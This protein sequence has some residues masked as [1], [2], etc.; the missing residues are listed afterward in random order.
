MRRISIAAFILFTIFNFAGC[1]ESEKIRT[2]RTKFELAKMK[3]DLD[4]M[5]I[6][7]K[8]LD[9]FGDKNAKN[10]LLVVL[11]AIKERELMLTAQSDHDHE[12]ALAAADKLITFSPG[13]KDAIKAIRESGQI[14]W[15]L[16][17]AQRAL[18]EFSDPINCKEVKAAEMP[19]GL[20]E[21]G[22][23]KWR[24]DTIQNCLIVL[25]KTIDDPKGSFGSSTK[26]ALKEEFP[27]MK[28]VQLNDELV[29]TVSKAAAEHAKSIMEAS[30]EESKF[31]AIA[32]A[33]NLVSK[34]K[35]LDPQFKGSVQI[36]D[37]LDKAHSEMVYSAAWRIFMLGSLSFYEA[38]GLHDTAVKLLNNALQSRYTTVS[39]QWTR[40]SPI[41]DSGYQ[42]IKNNYISAM[43]NSAKNLASYKSGSAI[44]IAEEAQRFA[45]I[46]SSGVERLMQ[47]T[48]SLIDFRRAG[49]ETTDEFNASIQKFK[50]ALPNKSE[51][52][53]FSD[54]AK[55]VVGYCLYKHPET[56][57]IIQKNEGMFT[58]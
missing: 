21:E 25:G 30:M 56:K 2:E 37:L 46:C 31:T 18:V 57:D 54:A 19:L 34:A 58:L 10:D 11:N 12:A 3:Q 8:N 29:S 24:V 20:D 42:N 15:L 47:P 43:N 39:S 13:N 33:R 7:L 35:A 36:E 14:F 41:M 48:G 51:R 4:Q 49:V 9:E 44:A 28:V 22:K 17:H 32:R 40:I 52:D 27:K 16:D 45:L 23:N 6:S 26:K 5:F 53:Q 38:N 50:A 55:T 1:G